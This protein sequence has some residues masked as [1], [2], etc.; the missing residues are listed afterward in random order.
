[1]ALKDEMP[2]TAQWVAERRKQYGDAWVDDMVRRAAKGEQDCCYAMEQSPGGYRV[3]G[4]PMAKEMTTAKHDLLGRCLM[5]GMEFVGFMR[6]PPNWPQ[7][8]ADGAH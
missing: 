6:T 1:M 5:L 7:G 3:F 4:A 8:G 2:K